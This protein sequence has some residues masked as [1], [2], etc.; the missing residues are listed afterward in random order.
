MR[1]SEKTKNVVS[2]LLQSILPPNLAVWWLRVRE[3]HSWNQAT[4]WSCNHLI[5]GWYGF[6]GGFPPPILVAIGL[7]EEETVH[8]YFVTWTQWDHLIRRLCNS[9]EKFPFVSTMPSLVVIDSTKEEVLHFQS[10]T[11]LDVTTWSGGDWFCMDVSCPES[12][13]CIYYASFCWK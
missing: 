8:F 13:H 6:I 2:P 11:W 1:S 12:R 7:A 4:M 9:T 3:A 10:I 5:W